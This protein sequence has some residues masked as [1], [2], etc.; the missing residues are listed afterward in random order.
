MRHPMLLD[1]ERS[2]LVVIDVQE[3]YRRVLH[4]WEQVTAA[5]SV[6][7][8]GARL[9]GVPV[10]ATEQYPRGLGHTAAEVAQHFPPDLVVSEKLSMSCCGASDFLARLER[11]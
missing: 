10:L 2:V 5:T 6:L 7:V 9:L 3:A 4:G 1:R 8:R 11:A